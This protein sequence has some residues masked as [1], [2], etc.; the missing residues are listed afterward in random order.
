MGYNQGNKMKKG[1][2]GSGDFKGKKREFPFHINEDLIVGCIG[3]HIT[4]LM[5]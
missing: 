1:G 5:D 4:S 2:V 3:N